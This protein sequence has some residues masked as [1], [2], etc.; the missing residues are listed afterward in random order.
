MKSK[1]CIS[2]GSLVIKNNLGT[3]D[4]FIS[5]VEEGDVFKVLYDDTSADGYIQAT[6][7]DGDVNLDN[8]EE[9]NWLVDCLFKGWTDSWDDPSDITVNYYI[10][11]Y[12]V[13][14]YEDQLYLENEGECFHT[15]KLSNKQ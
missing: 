13:C 2:Y 10:D 12:R 1:L 14:K 4:E 5:E 11:T 7:F 6:S 3:N 9:V 15:K 8:L